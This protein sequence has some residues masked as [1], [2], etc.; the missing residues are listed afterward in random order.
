MIAIRLKRVG[1]KNIKKWRIVVTKS[2]SPRDGRFLEEIGSYNSL[3]NPP[4]TEVKLDR[5]EMWLK[6]GAKPSETVRALMKRVKK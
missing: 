4:E 6:K 2:Q 1:T 3:K 5:Y